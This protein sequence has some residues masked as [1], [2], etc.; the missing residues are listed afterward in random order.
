MSESGLDA[1]GSILNLTLGLLTLYLVGRNKSARWNEKIAG[2]AFAWMFIGKSIVNMSTYLID[3][4]SSGDIDFEN[5]VATSTVQFLQALVMYSDEI[6]TTTIFIL[7]LFYPIPLLRTKRQIKIG[8]TIIFSFLIYRAIVFTAFGPNILFIPGAIYLLPGLVWGANYIRFR[9][10]EITKIESDAKHIAD[11][12]LI[13]LI[14]LMGGIWLY[15]PGMLFQ[16]N[17]FY[18]IDVWGAS[19]SSDLYDYSWQA[20]YAISVGLGICIM[21][22]EIYCATKR[23]IS[24]IGIV[25]LLYFTVGFAGYF[26]LSKTATTGSS[27]DQLQLTWDMFTFSVHY[28]IMRPVI[29]MFILLNYGLVK[30]ENPTDFRIAKTGTIVLVVVSTSVLLELIQYVIPISEII[31]AAILGIIIAV[32]VG[33]EEKVFNNLI[34]EFKPLND[35]LDEM[36]FT[37]PEIELDGS[38]SKKLNLAFLTYIG[39]TL[40]LAFVIGMTDGLGGV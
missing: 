3:S 24:P 31:S 26:I 11:V 21:F 25:F 4:N 18:T 34:T 23:R 30:A 32:G 13:C 35:I 9:Q 6:F 5:V 17:Y 14:L 28:D 22:M 33:W 16:A 12:S 10:L 39:V 36:H 20:F 38:I 29:A 19:L 1:V 7:C 15:W 8:L 27:L 40:L 2:L 37:T